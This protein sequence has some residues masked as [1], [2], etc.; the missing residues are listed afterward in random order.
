MPPVMPSFVRM[1]VPL[2]FAAAA[3]YLFV[4]RPTGPSLALGTPFVVL[5]LALRLWASGSIE[6]NRALATG[7]PYRLVRHPLYVGSSLLVLGFAV[8]SGSLRV[9]APLLA[10]FLAVYLPVVRREE[11]AL[12]ER[13]GDEFGRWRDAVPAFVPRLTARLPRGGPGGFAWSSVVRHREWRSVLGALLLLGFL[14]A[15]AWLGR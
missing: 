11:A 15:R 6:K 12:A 13:F 2:G 4:A 1:R 14:V 10:L 3:V 5:G 7:G 9:G 8:A